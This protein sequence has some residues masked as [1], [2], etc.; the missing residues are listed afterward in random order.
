MQGSSNKKTVTQPE[1]FVYN[2][3]VLCRVVTE[4]ARDIQKKGYNVVSPEMIS[5]ASEYL[6]AKDP[7][8]LLQN[9]IKYSYKH[10]E[11]IKKRN[12]NFFG[13]EASKIFPDLP[14]SIIELFCKLLYLE[15]GDNQRVISEEQ[16]EEVW[17]IFESFVKISIN[18]IHQ[19]RKPCI[20][21]YE[22]GREKKRYTMK[23][24]KEIDL[25]PICELWK[26][27]LIFNLPN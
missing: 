1:K 19:E 4:I 12:E 6:K 7:E 18:Y 15:D 14:S 10:W 9:F 17:I 5:L 21:I 11:K 27:E 23:F 13:E 26:I 16:R 3:E 2:L 22:D 24:F 25:E 8:K 20:K